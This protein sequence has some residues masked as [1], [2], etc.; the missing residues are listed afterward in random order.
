[1]DLNRKTS[2]VLDNKVIHTQYFGEIVLNDIL[3]QM[4]EWRDILQVNKSVKY[5]IFDYTDANLNYLSPA[6]VGE[7]S[8][9]TPLLIEPYPQLIMLGVMPHDLSFGLAKMWEKQINLDESQTKIFRDL[10]SVFEH[11]DKLE[12]AVDG[13]SS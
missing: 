10:E 3:E 4:A 1:M 9:N 12:R 6:D 7:I 8:E 11:I 2:L 13:K 5:L